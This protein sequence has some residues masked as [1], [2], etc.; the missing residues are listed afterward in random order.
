MEE[1]SYRPRKFEIFLN[2]LP[3]RMFFWFMT[4]IRLFID[5][6]CN[7]SRI[8]ID[9]TGSLVIQRARKEDHGR[10]QCSAK[11]LAATRDTRP[12]RLKIHGKFYALDEGT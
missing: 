2:S 7:F 10:Y 9:D 1:V 8:R 12:I 6:N 5:D 3:S 4:G 11:N